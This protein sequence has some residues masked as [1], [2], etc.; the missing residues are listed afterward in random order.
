[1]LRNLH[2]DDF[3]FID[4]ALSSETRTQLSKKPDKSTKQIDS[5]KIHFQVM[6]PELVNSLT[7]QLIGK[8]PNTYTYTKVICHKAP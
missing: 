8:K 2:K 1:M 3:P 4:R 6:D 7:A 5:L